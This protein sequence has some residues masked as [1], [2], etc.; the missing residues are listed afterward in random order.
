MDD[1]KTAICNHSVGEV[2]LTVSFFS[3]VVAV[4]SLRRVERSSLGHATTLLAAL[5]LD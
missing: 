4:G 5:A 3:F 2:T 1:Y